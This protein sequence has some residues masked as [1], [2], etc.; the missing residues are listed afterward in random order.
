VKKILVTGGNGFLGN[1][2]VTKLKK[3]YN[4]KSLGVSKKNDYSIDLLDEKKINLFF[5]NKKFDYIIHC[6]GNVPGGGKNLLSKKHYIQNHVMTKNIIKFS[7]SKIIFISSYKVYQN[8]AKIGFPYKINNN[9]INDYSSSKIASENLIINKKNNYLIL[10]LPSIFGNGVKNGLLYKVIK[11]KYIFKDKIDQNWSILDVKHTLKPV[12]KFIEQNLNKG[13]YNLSYNVEYS[14]SSILNFIYKNQNLKIKI[15]DKKK[16][17]LYTD[18][19]LARSAKELKQDLI[20]YTN[21][22]LKN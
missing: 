6:A 18:S 21:Y 19:K 11:N 9:Q 8:Q 4:V 10:R 3:N 1:F 5:K 16:F 12:K 15:R 7:N 17:F 22:V 13:I 14:M 2:F 20:D